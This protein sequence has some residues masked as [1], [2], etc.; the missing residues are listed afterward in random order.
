MLF[1]SARHTNNLKAIVEFYTAVLL[2]EVLG[3][4]QAHE[5]YNGVFLGRKDLDWHL[6]FTESDEESIHISDED[7]ILVFYPTNKKDY[8][9]IIKRIEKLKILLLKPK[10]S[11]WTKNGILIKDPDGFNIILSNRY[12]S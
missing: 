7:D 8:E 9:A 11:Y 6:E 5:K 4:F 2:F 1:R 3:E 12:I 10:N